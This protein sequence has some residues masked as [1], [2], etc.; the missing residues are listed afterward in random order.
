MIG[1]SVA[2]DI[3]YDI[4]VIPDPDEPIETVPNFADFKQ[5]GKTLYVWSHSKNKILGQPAW[6][7]LLQNQNH[8]FDRLVQL[9]EFYGFTEMTL[10]DGSIEWEMAD[11]N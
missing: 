11:L 3:D 9:A 8:A 10:F 1:D 7:M 6:A 4:P 5:K 2:P